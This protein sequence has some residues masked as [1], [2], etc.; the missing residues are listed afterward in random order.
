M[1]KPNAVAQGLVG[2]ILS[3]VERTGFRIVA[4]ASRTLTTDEAAG[5]YDVH[6]GKPFFEPLIR[7]VTSGP[8][9]GLIL[10][11]P[12]AVVRLRE[13]VG[14]TDP[15]EAHP[16]TIRASYGKSIRENAVHAADSPGRFTHES[17]IYFGSSTWSDTA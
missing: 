6:A 12:D 15:A 16:G 10:E 1:I 9:V 11:A 5:I 2:E 8:S 13:T 4:V 7:F 3:A 17:T 14:A